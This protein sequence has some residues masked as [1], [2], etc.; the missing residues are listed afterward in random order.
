MSKKP[1]EAKHTPEPWEY[2]HEGTDEDGDL[3]D[4]Q[5]VGSDENKIEILV[6]CGCCYG[7][8]CSLANAKRI[9]ACVNACAGMDDPR[10]TIENLVK[11]AAIHNACGYSIGK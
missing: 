4:F 5:L 3:R 1:N 2:G 8:S 10:E 6:S 7:I 9:V 11:L